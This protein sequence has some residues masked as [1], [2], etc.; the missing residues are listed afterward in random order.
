MPQFVVLP[1]QFSRM[2]THLRKLGADLTIEKAPE[3]LVGRYLTD[4]SQPEQDYGLA[5]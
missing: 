4:I 3:K 1:D 2:V 5:Y